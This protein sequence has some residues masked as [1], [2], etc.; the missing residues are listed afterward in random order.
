MST[1]DEQ[2]RRELIKRLRG[3][4]GGE[5]MY[6]GIGTKEGAK[7][8]PYLKY[9]KK[10]KGKSKKPSYAQYQKAESQKALKLKKQRKAPYGYTKSGAVRRKPCKLGVN[11]KT[12]ECKKAPYGFTASGNIRRKPLKRK[13]PK[14]KPKKIG[15]P[16]D[17]IERMMAGENLD[18]NIQIKPKPKKKRTLNLTLRRFNECVRR[19]RRDNPEIS[20]REA[21]QIVKNNM[22]YETGECNPPVGEGLMDRY[23]QRRS[24]SRMYAPERDELSRRIIEAG[25][26]NEQVMKYNQMVE[27]TEYQTEYMYEPPSYEKVMAEQGESPPSYEEALGMGVMDYY[28]GEMDD[29]M[30]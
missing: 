4:Y 22:N 8:N 19:Y 26:S 13:A 29:I 21:Q 11:R 18:R 23:G 10:Y 3:I 25:T 5:A 14:R 6:G 20:Q 15:P 27:P 12:G 24:R 7:K 16:E 9:L 1:L 2:S 28:G 17:F 30:Y